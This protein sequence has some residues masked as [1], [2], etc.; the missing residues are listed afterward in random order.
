MAI[1]RKV[2]F[3][4]RWVKSSRAIKTWVSAWK[5]PKPTS[6]AAILSQHVRSAALLCLRLLQVLLFWQSL[7]ARCWRA[8]HYVHTDTEN[9]VIKLF[10]FCGATRELKSFTI[11]SF[12]LRK[13]SR[14]RN[15]AMK[16]KLRYESLF[17]LTIYWWN[18]LFKHDAICARKKIA[19]KFNKLRGSL[20]AK[21]EAEHKIKDSC[22]SKG[23]TFHHAFFNKRND[24]SPLQWYGY[25]CPFP[26]RQ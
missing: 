7:M 21:R 19:N 3:K 24:V 18:F 6:K 4:C 15:D 17:F 14:V 9:C 2:L 23:K 26:N 25:L 11:P 13:L 1:N 20:K 8:E 10:R 22:W 12:C 16:M 5:F